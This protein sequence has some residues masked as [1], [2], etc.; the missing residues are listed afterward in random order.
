MNLK[1]GLLRLAEFKVKNI[2]EK[3]R[4]FS[5]YL[6][7]FKVVFL[8]S[9]DEFLKS[10]SRTFSMLWIQCLFTRCLLIFF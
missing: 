2:F 7:I 8:P 1:W 5:N 4:V 6:K 3:N 10:L 9:R